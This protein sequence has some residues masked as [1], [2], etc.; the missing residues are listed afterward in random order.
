[1]GQ[2]SAR[3]IFADGTLGPIRAIAETNDERP[4]GFPQMVR[5]GAYL[6]F[7]WTDTARGRVAS[8]GDHRIAMA[9]SLAGTGDR[10]PSHSRLSI[11]IACIHGAG[12]GGHVDQG[13]A[14]AGP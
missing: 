11:H 4:S 13:M 7:S 6:V 12:V 2:V 14:A 3:R 5:S 9:F 10:V 1:M 8:R